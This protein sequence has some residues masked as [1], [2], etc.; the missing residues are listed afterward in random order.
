M[1]NAVGLWRGEATS[2]IIRWFNWRWNGCLPAATK[3]MHWQMDRNS[4]RFRGRSIEHHFLQRETA[5]RPAGKERSW[6][7]HG[8]ENET[9]SNC[10]IQR[11]RRRRLGMRVALRSAAE[12]KSSGVTAMET[13]QP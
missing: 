6:Q 7:E 10:E 3:P 12:S 8:L 5:P 1:N 11:K 4:S 9:Q 13:S 2:A